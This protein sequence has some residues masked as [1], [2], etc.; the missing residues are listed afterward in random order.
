MTRTK[1]LLLAVAVSFLLSLPA[2]FAS[3][4]S[5]AGDDDPLFPCDPTPKAVRKCQ[6]AGGTF[7]FAQCRCVF[8]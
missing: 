5:A 8:P 3:P 7:D 4:K 2:A 6:V 1:V